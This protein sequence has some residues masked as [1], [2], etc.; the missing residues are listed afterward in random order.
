MN[1][2][3]PRD[4][5]PLYD[6]AALRA[7]EAAATAHLGGDAFELMRRAGQAAWRELL[8]RWP[9]A[10]RI[11]VVCGPGNNGGDG[12]VLARHAFD[13]GREVCVVRL[14]AHAPRGGLAQHACAAYRDGG[15]RI[16]R[17]DGALPAADVLVDALFGIGLSRAPDEPCGALIDAINAAP[18]PV[19]ALDAPS[20]IDA[21]S[22]S[23]P[24][25][26]IRAEATLQFIAAHAGLYTGDALDHGG[27]LSLAG[28]DVPGD[29]LVQVKP[30]AGCLRAE[31]LPARFRP[32][33]RN[34]HKGRSGHVLCIGG[35][36]GKGGAVMLAAEAALRC[37]A[38]LVSVA[39]RAEHVAALLARRPEAMVQAVE[40][41]TVPPPLFQ[42]ADVLAVGPGL[43]EGEWGA[44][45]HAAA[46]ACGKPLVLDADALNLLARNAQSPP[47]GTVLTPHPGEAARLLGISGS[48]VQAN[49]FAAAHLLCAC[50]GCAVVLKGAGSVVAAPGE[51]PQVIAAGN[52][53]L[54]VGGTGD[55][56]T[57]CI[58]ALRAQGF[59]A[60]DAAAT[61]A[62]LHAAAGDLAA[63]AGGE[64]GLLPS[65][66]F[67]PLRRLVNP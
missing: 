38:G 50:F 19:L 63:Q 5:E 45:L 58:A 42:R 59:S 47:A 41:A 57:G 53:G 25:K 39:T 28:L 34:S 36:A 54:A 49:R 55:V 20:G 16:E 18:A 66:L 8:R 6:S 67:E 11:V 7:I 17:Y 62:L 31:D 1:T 3:R 32:R 30:V 44:A 26:A 35:D 37:G 22:G 29:V 64:R 51:L 21:D 10:Q 4:P 2:A 60:F 33:P 24:G 61:G 40:S 65:D 56:L 14:E 43:G 27:A 15:G 52:P 12:Y 9:Q 23:A 13:S 46:L 48:E